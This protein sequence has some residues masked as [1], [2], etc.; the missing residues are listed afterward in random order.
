M[1]A[2]KQR[3]RHKAMGLSIA[4]GHWSSLVA[5]VLNMGYLPKYEWSHWGSLSISILTPLALVLV[6]GHVSPLPTLLVLI[7]SCALGNHALHYIHD[8]GVADDHDASAIVID[9]VAGSAVAMLAVPAMLPLL[10][11]E[12]TLA[13]GLLC[14]LLVGWVFRFFDIMKPFPAEQ[15]DTLWH[16]PFAVMADDL[17]AGFYAA[18]VGVAFALVD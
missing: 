10:G 5:T 6:D 18:L 11:W 9:E 13:N 8:H 2:V 14:A 12:P 16:H 3:R 4:R 17:V 1:N 15:F 7:L